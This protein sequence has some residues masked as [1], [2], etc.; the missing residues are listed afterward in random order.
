MLIYVLKPL[1]VSDAPEK[2]GKDFHIGADN[3]TFTDLEV[4][5]KDVEK[6]TKL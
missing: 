6:A 3:P 4:M 5:G 1:Q 2:A